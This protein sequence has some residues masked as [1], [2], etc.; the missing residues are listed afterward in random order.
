MVAA[1]PQQMAEKY[2][3]WTDKI[4]ADVLADLTEAQVHGRLRKAQARWE[5]AAGK[6]GDGDL[7]KALTE[8]GEILAAPAPGAKAKTPSVLKSVG[9]TGADMDK[10]GR[11]VS[12]I[13]DEVLLKMDRPSIV[14][15][16]E[17][18]A[19]EYGRTGSVV[20]ADRVLMAAA[21]VVASAPMT[22]TAQAA[23]RRGVREDLAREYGQWIGEVPDEVL[24]KLDAAELVDRCE[25]AKG[26]EARGKADP[27]PGMIHGYYDRARMVLKSLPQAE[28]EAEAARLEK[29]AM[30]VDE[31][32]LSRGYAER[33]RRLR[34]DNPQAPA[35]QRPG[36]LGKAVQAPELAAVPRVLHK[37]QGAAKTPKPV[38]KPPVKRRQSS[39]SKVDAT[40]VG[41]GLDALEAALLL[42]RKHPDLNKADAR[43]QRTVDELLDVADEMF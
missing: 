32:Q 43:T 14:K 8:A 28:V 31:P 29:S 42:L 27:V 37:A 26:L 9:V 12:R 33:A 39:M 10:H 7:T 40:R 13:P 34:A 3:Q 17:V 38:Q 30:L 19:A 4:P 2:G 35:V 22:K 36:W 41:A 18:A 25:Y 24:A 21:H 1:V 5:T 6:G 23:Y 15:R 16:A 11:W 20:D